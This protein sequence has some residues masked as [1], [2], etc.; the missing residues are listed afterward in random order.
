MFVP[1]V[2]TPVGGIDE[3]ISVGDNGYVA[4]W[5]SKSFSSAIENIL[6]SKF[7]PDT[8]KASVSHLT[9]ESWANNVIELLT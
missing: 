1:V 3:L 9:K 7:N 5:D 2:S 8:I 6:S 4:G